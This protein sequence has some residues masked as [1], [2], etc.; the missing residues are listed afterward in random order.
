MKGIDVLLTNMHICSY[1]FNFP[2]KEEQKPVRTSLHYG[3][4][5]TQ[6]KTVAWRYRNVTEK[7]A[8]MT[9]FRSGSII[10]SYQILAWNGLKLQWISKMNW[11]L[12]LEAI[13]QIIFLYA[14]FGF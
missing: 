3:F 12:P 5:S 2:V 10:R 9:H 14:R 11:K 1:V 13:A 8:E 7:N 6:G 4:L